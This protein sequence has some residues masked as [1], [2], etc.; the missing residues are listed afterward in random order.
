MATSCNSDVLKETIVRHR[1]HVAMT[2]RGLRISESPSGQQEQ[3][4]REA[5]CPWAHASR[6]S[7][8]SSTLVAELRRST[9]DL[10]E[11]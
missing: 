10:E 3:I 8:A 11:K 4:P 9:A 1:S 7:P 6:E 5:S 2:G